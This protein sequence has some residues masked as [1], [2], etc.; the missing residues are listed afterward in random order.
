MA[1]R[2]NSLFPPHPRGKVRVQPHSVTPARQ[3]VP[4]SRKRRLISFNLDFRFQWSVINQVS[5]LDMM[6]IIFALDDWT[7]KRYANA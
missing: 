3:T 7:Q 5:H 4:A 2:G 1:L 6:N